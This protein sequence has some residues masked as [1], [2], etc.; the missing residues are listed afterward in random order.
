MA[1]IKKSKR[2]R[3]LPEKTYYDVSKHKQNNKE[4][5]NSKEWRIT[6][7]SYVNAY[8]LCEVCKVKN[9]VVVGDEVHHII[10]WQDGGD[11]FNED[12]LLHVCRECHKELTTYYK[13]HKMIWCKVRLRVI[14]ILDK[15]ASI[16]D[17]D[18]NI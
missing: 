8:P 12:N 10:E 14:K 9:K 18:N 4:F 5:Y 15:I 3:Y 1:Y 6:R 11:K 13:K 7:T 17:R 2:K 16:G